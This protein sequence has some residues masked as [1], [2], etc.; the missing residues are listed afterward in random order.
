MTRK[1]IEQKRAGEETT[2]TESPRL[3]PVIDLMEALQK[4]LRA[5]P[6]KKAPAKATQAV[7]QAAA[8]IKPRA[9]RKG[10]RKAG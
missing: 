6:A 9:T 8:T 7:A 3:A 10:S 4:S 2:A 5:S 1:L